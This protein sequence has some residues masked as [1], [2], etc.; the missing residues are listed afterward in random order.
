MSPYALCLTPAFIAPS[1]PCI[2]RRRPRFQF[3]CSVTEI[4]S[5]SDIM[6]RCVDLAKNALGQTRPNPPVGCVLLSPDGKILGEGFHARAGS[7]HAE[8]AAL[9]DA[10]D[11]GNSVK[12]ATAYVTLEPCNHFGRTPPC[13]RT[14]MQAGVKKVKVGMV[15]PNPRVDGGG[16]ERLRRGGVEVE[17]GVEEQICKDLVEGF[18]RRVEK[19][20]PIGV[21][22]YAMTLDGKIASEQ[23]KSKWV[24]GEYARKRVHAIRRSADAIVVG[25]QTVRMDDPRLT[26]RDVPRNGLLE[27]IRVVMTRSMR[28]P[29]KARMWASA[30]DI[31]TVVLT[32]VDHGQP[33]LVSELRD[34]GVVVEEVPGLQADDAM[35][36]LY[37]R[38][39]LNVLWECGGALAANAIGDGAVQKVH[40]FV[41]PKLIGGA[42][43]PSPVGS[44][45]LGLEMTHAMELSRRSVE[46]FENGDILVSGYLE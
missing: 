8:V 36:Y 31:E 30:R 13:S 14:L 46:T 11:K 18:V 29:R 27:P 43:A 28:L 2:S 6:H 10:A 15:D 22:K 38:D 41:A 34:K 5:D 21:L 1:L 12:G 3:T 7:A 44:P 9:A 24:T 33:E 45:A 16:I 35:A 39:C 4:S 32:G 40:A 25:G 42:G 19:K 37:E 26:V 23:G 20:R 17:V